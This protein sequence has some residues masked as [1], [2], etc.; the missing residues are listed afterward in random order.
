MPQLTKLMRCSEWVKITDADAISDN[1]SVTS[2][3]NIEICTAIAIADSLT[4]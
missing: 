2:A 4:V 1:L 3:K